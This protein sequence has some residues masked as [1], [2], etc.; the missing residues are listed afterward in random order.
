MLRTDRSRSSGR[1]LVGTTTETDGRRPA[2]ARTEVLEILSGIR[3]GW[4]VLIVGSRLVM[5]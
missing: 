3:A 4:S 5:S 2:L 1:F